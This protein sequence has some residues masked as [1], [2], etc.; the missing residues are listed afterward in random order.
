MIVKP[1]SAYTQADRDRV[2]G[3]REYQKLKESLACYRP[4]N[5]EARLDELDTLCQPRRAQQHDFLRS[6][7]VPFYIAYCSIVGIYIILGGLQ[8]AAITDAVQGILILIMSVILIPV[9]LHRI[10]GVHALHEM[11]P[12][13][14]FQLVGTSASS[15]YAWYSI[16]AITLGSLVQIIGLS[17]NMSASGSATNEN[18]ARFGMIGGGFTKRIV[19]IGWMFCGLLA[20]ALLSNALTPSESDR[21]WAH[22]PAH[23]WARDSSD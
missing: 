1:E 16:A 18:T 2:N 19:L 11:L 8:A 9:G 23:S 12:A 10:G 15:E 6:K 14:T 22:S 5:P 21:A 17:H 20:I 7:P 3:F 4:I 13:S